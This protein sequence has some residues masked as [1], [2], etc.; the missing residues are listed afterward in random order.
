VLLLALPHAL[1]RATTAAIAP[2][3]S[4]RR[5]VKRPF[6]AFLCTHSALSPT[7]PNGQSLQAFSSPERVCGERQRKCERG[8]SY[9]DHPELEHS[10]YD[11]LAQRPFERVGG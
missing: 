4:R 11:D 6:I 2:R 10:R 8:H 5:G 1:V 9:E 7:G 3:D